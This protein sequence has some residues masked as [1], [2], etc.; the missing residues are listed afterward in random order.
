M[1][2]F[3]YEPKIYKTIGKAKLERVLNRL[4]PDPDS[5]VHCSDRKYYLIED[6]AEFMAK[7]SPRNFVYKKDDN[8]C[9]DAV[10]IF[11]GNASDAEHGNVVAMDCIVRREGRKGTH[12]CIAFLN[13]TEDGLVYGEPQN[14]KI[15][16][17]NVTKIERLIA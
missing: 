17:Y 5:Y 9:D 6:R 16:D 12:G 15:K 3:S 11:R 8:D 7:Y 14:G 4:A 2:W 1:G 13:D 10:R